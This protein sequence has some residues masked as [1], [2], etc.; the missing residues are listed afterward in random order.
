MLQLVL[1]AD[2]RGEDV[3]GGADFRVCRRRCLGV[4][5]CSPILLFE[6]G[7]KGRCPLEGKTLQQFALIE[8]EIVGLAELIDIDLEAALH[9][10]DAVSGRIEALAAERLAEEREGGA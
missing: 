8:I 1:P 10:A 2:E 5:R 3:G 6:L 9:Q 7:R 4:S